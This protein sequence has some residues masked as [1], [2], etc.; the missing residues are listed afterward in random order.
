M[1]TAFYGVYLWPALADCNKTGKKERKKERFKNS[2][3]TVKEIVPCKLELAPNS[4]GTLDS[5]AVQTEAH[6][7]KQICS[8]Y[9]IF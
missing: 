8:W 4:L 6:L 1:I 7:V 5:R 3:I 9:F 2:F